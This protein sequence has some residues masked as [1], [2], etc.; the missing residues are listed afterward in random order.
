MK[1]SL[2]GMDGV[3]QTMEWRVVAGKMG[4]FGPWK[5]QLPAKA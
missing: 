4:G 1:K 2:Q 5:Q 3:R